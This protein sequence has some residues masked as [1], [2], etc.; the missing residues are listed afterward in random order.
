MGY[1]AAAVP[2]G[3]SGQEEQVSRGDT[4]EKRRR[5]DE[6]N[7]SLEE[8]RWR[9]ADAS[10]TVE[11]TSHIVEDDSGESDDTGSGDNPYGVDYSRDD[12]PIV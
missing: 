5:A 4:T 8:T 9:K 12:S 2:G 11:D 3:R 10:H 6:K 1:D 7:N